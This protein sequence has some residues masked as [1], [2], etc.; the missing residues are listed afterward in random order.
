MSKLVCH[1]WRRAVPPPQRRRKLPWLLMPYRRTKF[2]PPHRPDQKRRAEFHCVLANGGLHLHRLRI[3]RDTGGARFIGSYD[4][5]W[6]FLAHRPSRGHALLNLH[7]DR[8]IPLSDYAWWSGAG[9]KGTPDPSPNLRPML[10][11]AATLSSPPLAPNV[12]CIAAAIADGLGAD[13]TTDYPCLSVWRAPLIAFWLHDLIGVLEDDAVESLRTRELRFMHIPFRPG[14]LADGEHVDG[15]Y[16]VESRGEL[17]MVIRT[18]VSHALIADA[19]E[20]PW[21]CFRVF[22]QTHRHL[23]GGVI[24]MTWTRLPTLGGRMLFVA[25]GC[26]RS[27]D[28][29]DF[30]GYQDG[31]YFLDEKGSRSAEAMWSPPLEPW[32][33]CYSCNDNG[34][35]VPPIDDDV[36]R[37]FPH[38]APSNYSCP[39]WFLP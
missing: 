10:I 28:T 15:R 14:N 38:R 4:G 23:P 37:W 27:Y 21:T 20:V 22:Q 7:T 34:R 5:G 32:G 35:W 6:L 29:A 2:L 3:G 16:L 31:V 33:R 1:D 13:G 18:I 12:P 24:E 25:R 17:L 11:L 30:P 9:L 26:S 19:D 39:V 8:R 36:R